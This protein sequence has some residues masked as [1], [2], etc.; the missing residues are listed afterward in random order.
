MPQSNYDC[1]AHALTIYMSK[2]RPAYLSVESMWSK[3]LEKFPYADRHGIDTDEA[4]AILGEKFYL[5]PLTGDLTNTI[6]KKPAA[7]GYWK[8]FKLKI[9]RFNGYHWVYVKEDYNNGM[10]QILDENGERIIHKSELAFFDLKNFRLNGIGCCAIK[11][12]KNA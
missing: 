7:N 10:I 9:T 3:I 11:E 1:F 6:L 4:L 5:T 2:N 8:L 12:N